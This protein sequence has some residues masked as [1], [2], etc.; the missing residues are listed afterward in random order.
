MEYFTGAN[1]CD[2]MH[3]RILEVCPSAQGELSNPEE[4][5]RSV[6]SRFNLCCPSPCHWERILGE[7]E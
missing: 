2:W 6:I 1:A 3:G 4:P 5:Y 7:E